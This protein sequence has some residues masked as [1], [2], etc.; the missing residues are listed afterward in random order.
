MDNANQH[1]FR[2]KSS[3]LHRWENKWVQTAVLHLLKKSTVKS[4]YKT[5]VCTGATVVGFQKVALFI[6]YL[7]S[8][9][10]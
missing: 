6:A 8:L 9:L 7:S 10:Q 3:N 4:P 1:F 2:S 5:A